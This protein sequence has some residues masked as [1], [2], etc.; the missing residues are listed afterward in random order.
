MGGARII[1][2]FL[3][4]KGNTRRTQTRGKWIGL[5]LPPITTTE[6]SKYTL[7]DVIDASW[8]SLD[9][10]KT[11]RARCGGRRASLFAV[12]LDNGRAFGTLRPLLL[13]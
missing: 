3:E 9:S 8:S 11:M 12:D 5:I 13:N 2:I 7:S 6:S 10:M 4:E 1:A